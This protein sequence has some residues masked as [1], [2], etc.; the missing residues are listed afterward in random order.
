[1]VGNGHVMLFLYAFLGLQA[2]A[3]LDPRN[4]WQ[5]KTSNNS[6]LVF[7]DFQEIARTEAGEIRSVQVRIEGE[8][9]GFQNLVHM[10]LNLCC[11]LCFLMGISFS[12]F[13][14]VKQFE[15]PRIYSSSSIIRSLHLN[16]NGKSCE[17]LSMCSKTVNLFT[18]ADL[19]SLF[20][21][22]SV[23]LT[24]SGKGVT[25]PSPIFF[26]SL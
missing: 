22:F 16:L 25:S 6:P 7:T 2:F 10:L 8:D 14:Q 15:L 23:I 4:P 24:D 20:L 18:W 3:A 19:P 11:F 12:T 17:T 26:H 5:N 21:F 9:E 13:I 1:M